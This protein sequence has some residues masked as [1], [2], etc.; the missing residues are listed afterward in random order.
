[1]KIC[2]IKTNICAVWNSGFQATVS[3]MILEARLSKNIDF[4]AKS[5]H[6]FIRGHQA[7]HRLLDASKIL[8]MAML[9]VT[10][11]TTQVDAKNRVP[12]M[13]ICNGFTRLALDLPMHHASFAKH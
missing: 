5:L 4:P 6:I 1:M 3:K 10:M 2:K 7:H 12:V 8:S 9:R 11:R 13:Q